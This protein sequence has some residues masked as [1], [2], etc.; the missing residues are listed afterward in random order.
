MVELTII[1]STKYVRT[2]KVFLDPLSQISV[3]FMW[4]PSFCQNLSIWEMTNILLNIEGTC[5]WKKYNN[6]PVL[7][8]NGYYVLAIF[9]G[10]SDRI[11]LRVPLNFVPRKKKSEK[12]LIYRNLDYK[13]Q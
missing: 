12:Y 3:T 9:W 1:E 2:I 5:F 7:I 4:D 11:N 13:I 10:F 8:M 6:F